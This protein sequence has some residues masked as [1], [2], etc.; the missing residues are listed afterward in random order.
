M[1][2]GQQSAK[3]FVVLVVRPDLGGGRKDQ[4]CQADGD[5]G[6]AHVEEAE[7]PEPQEYSPGAPLI[8]VETVTSKSEAGTAVKR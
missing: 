4:G 1:R 5:A 3:Y 7:V 6:P 8:Y 2:I